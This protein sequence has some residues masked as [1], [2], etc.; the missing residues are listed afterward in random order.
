MTSFYHITP[1]PLK[2]T[3][4]RAIPFPAAESCHSTMTATSSRIRNGVITALVFSSICG[5]AV[6][7]SKSSQE[8][9]VTYKEVR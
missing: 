2:I 3:S 9:Q 8:L 5:G 7:R 1:A 6:I 4:F